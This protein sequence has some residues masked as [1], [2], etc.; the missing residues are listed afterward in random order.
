LHHYRLVLVVIFYL[1]Q[2]LLVVGNQ[3]VVLAF[4]R[5]VMVLLMVVL[6]LQLASIISRQLLCFV[7]EIVL[8]EGIYCWH[9]RPLQFQEEEVAEH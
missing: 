2:L 9:R 4:N 1:H 7:I 3:M 5:L 8:V 6:H